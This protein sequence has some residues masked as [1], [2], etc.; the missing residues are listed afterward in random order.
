LLSAELAGGP[1]A[2]PSRPKLPQLARRNLR[3]GSAA[4][5]R[6]TAMVDHSQVV[7]R[8]IVDLCIARYRDSE[9]QFVG[10]KEAA[11]CALR[12]Q[13]LMSLHD[14]G[15]TGICASEPCY[16]LA[17]TL[18]ACLKDKTFDHKRLK[19]LGAICSGFAQAEAKRQRTQKRPK[20]AGKSKSLGRKGEAGRVRHAACILA[21]STRVMTNAYI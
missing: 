15:E 7:Y 21:P 18:D 6:L 11:L 10:M 1:S 3:N 4:L 8:G 12:S 20:S 17:W 5:R 14:A 2:S 13:L 16:K 19:E 9:A